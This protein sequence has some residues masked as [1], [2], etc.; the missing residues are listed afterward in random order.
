MTTPA[1]PP[2]KCPR[3]GE[4]I[5]GVEYRHSN[6]DYDGVSEYAC[7]NSKNCGYRLGRWTMEEIAPG[8][9]ESRRGIRGHVLAASKDKQ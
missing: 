6:E 5:Y 9:L 4:R 2:D 7:V 8:Y 3:C 1:T